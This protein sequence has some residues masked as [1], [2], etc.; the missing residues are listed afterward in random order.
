MNRVVVALIAAAFAA[1]CAQ[2]PTRTTNSNRADGK[3][4]EAQVNAIY[5]GL[6]RATAT[7][8]DAFKRARDGDVAGAS[9][10]LVA[11]REA[12]TAAGGRCMTTAGCEV[13]RVL[14]AQDALIERQAR[15]LIGGDNGEIAPV[16]ESVAPEAGSAASPVVGTLPQ[17]ARTVSLLRGKDLRTIIRL[18]EP[19]KAALEEWLT[20]MRPNLLEAYENYQYLRHRMWPVYSEAGLPEALLFG[21]LAKESGGKVHAVSRAGASGPLQFMPHTGARY[22]LTSTGGFDLRFDPAAATRANVAYLNDR[23]REL[24]D[25]L[26]LALGAYNGGEGR[27]RRLSP[28]GRRSFWEPGVWNSLP[29]ETRDYVPMVLA[30]AWLFLHPDQYNLKFPVIDARPAEVALKSSLSLSELAICMGQ[31]GN[32]RGWFRTLRNL[33]PRLDSNVRLV[34]GTKLALPQTAVAAYDRNCVAGR[35]V[36]TAMDL[37]MANPP[38]TPVLRV[39]STQ[40][41]YVVRRGETLS[42]IAR[43]FGCARIAP[44]AQAN[45]IKPPKY[46][47]RPGQRLLVP[48]CSA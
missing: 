28:N 44:I 8:D 12:L 46:S 2:T 48:I 25:N 18:N 38:V 13:E 36:A 33:N 27:M 14:A 21:I 32:A 45:R 11:A 9:A 4:D 24:N 35:Y 15:E 19:V 26:E 30:A 42:A 39:A 5:A 34:S 20:W 41:T 43:K 37:H 40:R 23:F 31:D 47:I 6:E 10:A 3:V 22:G 1:A 17:A 29:P 7:A 16:E